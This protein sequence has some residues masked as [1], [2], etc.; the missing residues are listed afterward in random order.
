MRFHPVSVG[1]PHIVLLLEKA[2]PLSQCLARGK[3]LERAKMFP[4]H[5]NIEFAFFRHAGDCRVVFYERGVGRTLFSATGSAALF[6]V[7]R[8]TGRIDA[9]L[10][11][12]TADNRIRIS[13]RK[14]IY[15]ENFSRLLCRGRF[16]L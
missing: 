14:K 12:D 3:I 11:L 7:L 13:G 16:R 4:Q 6:A 8:Q 5:T 9:E 1:N 2:W 15:I 10:F